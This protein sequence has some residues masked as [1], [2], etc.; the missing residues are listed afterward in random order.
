MADA[1]QNEAI[2]A[3]LT[4]HSSDTGSNRE[5]IVQKFFDI[6]LP[7]RLCSTLGGQV[8]GFNAEASKQIDI[9]ITNDLGIR[10]ERHKKTF[11]TAETLVSAISVKSTLD[12]EKLY[13]CLEN[14][15]SIPEPNAELINFRMLV[16][17]PYAEF[18]EKFPTYYIFAYDGFS[19]KSCQAALNEYYQT[20]TGTPLRRVPRA[21][22]VNN[23]YIIT[24]SRHDRKDASGNHIAAHSFYWAD[25]QGDMRGYPY[26]TMLNDMSAYCSWLNFMDLNIH[27]YFNAGLNPPTL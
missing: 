26:I 1:I 3:G 24:F 12:T 20:R 9:L 8:S 11:V 18:I 25:I 2:S 19:G 10:F 22:I 13:D 6:H 15:Q 21:I 14:L 4:G 17:N 7:R 5:D 16:N 23:K 27:P